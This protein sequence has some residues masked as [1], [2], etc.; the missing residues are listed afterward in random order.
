MQNLLCPLC[1]I[2]PACSSGRIVESTNLP[3]VFTTSQRRICDPS[4]ATRTQQTHQNPSTTHHFKMRSA[5]IAAFA[6][7]A[8]AVPLVA[9][10]D[11][12]VTDVDVVYATD[13]V[14]VTAGQEPSSTADAATTSAA[15]TTQQHYGHH[16]WWSSSSD[17]SS[18]AAPTSTESSTSAAAPTTSSTYV[19]PTTS[20]TYVVP[21]T[22]STYVAPTTSAAPSP[23]STSTSTWAASTSASATASGG[24]PSETD[25]TSTVVYH[26]NVHRNNHSASALT[27]NSTLASIA[28][29]IAQTCV[30][31]HNT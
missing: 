5:V 12:V 1:P 26:H 24:L 3:S 6:V 25:Y 7:G 4:K 29:S 17:A 31:E 18:S 13:V 9:R 23:T 15:P 2:T 27:W 22:S 8:I 16:P 11:V 10:Q 30:Y 19:A 14:T 20:S 21:T 28:L